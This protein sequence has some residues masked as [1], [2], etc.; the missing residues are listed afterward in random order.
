MKFTEIGV[1][2][3]P[4]GLKGAVV[5]KA[6]VA[7]NAQFR[8][9]ELLYLNQFES[10]VPYAIDDLAVLSTTTFKL[11]LRGVDTVAKA[12]ALRGT[13]I[14]QQNDLLSFSD[15]VDWVGMNVVN[16]DGHAI[17]EV[18]DTVEN[19]A[20][21]LL[22]VTSKAGEEQYIPLVEAFIVK[23]DLKEGSIT[24]DLPEGLLDL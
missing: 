13:V 3:K 20:Q 4:H 8:E 24:L 14:F 18:V 9:F 11:T 5:V 22:V 16:K 6:E 19:K 12:E 23:I 15:E 21:L 17:G 10:K 2:V 7:Y 1:I